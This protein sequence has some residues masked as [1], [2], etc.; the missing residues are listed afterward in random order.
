MS[1]VLSPPGSFK[2]KLQGV[3]LLTKVRMKVAEAAQ[4]IRKRFQVARQEFVDIMDA[5]ARVVAKVKEKSQ[6]VVPMVAKVSLGGFLVSQASN[7]VF[8]LFE[9]NNYFKQAD[10]GNILPLAHDLKDISEV[11]YRVRVQGDELELD[12][13]GELGKQ[14]LFSS[15]D[16]LTLG[17]E[18]FLVKL[19]PEPFRKEQEIRL[20]TVEDSK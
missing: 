20:S 4:G 14:G 9:G 18:P 5:E 13:P 19:L 17:C 6:V 12:S 15:N 2:A 16:L 11:D 1:N 8:S 7:R 10:G 3:T